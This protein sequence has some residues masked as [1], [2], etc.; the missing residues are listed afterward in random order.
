MPTQ[1]NTPIPI[2]EQQITHSKAAIIGGAIGGTIFLLLV[3]VVIFIPLFRHQRSCL[4]ITFRHCSTTPAPSIRND[5]MQE[6][7]IVQ[8]Q[9]MQAEGG[10]EPGEKVLGG[11]KDGE[12]MLGLGL[13]EMVGLEEMLRIEFPSP[14]RYELDA[15][16]FVEGRANWEIKL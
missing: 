11:G 14:S 6:E 13:E 8:Q 5:S 12:R 7:K 2:P 16:G 15:G 10:E 4:D 9:V 3:L 1:P